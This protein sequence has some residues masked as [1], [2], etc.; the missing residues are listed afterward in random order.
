LAILDDKTLGFLDYR[1]NTESKTDFKESGY[2][3]DYRGTHTIEVKAMLVCHK[4]VPIA[5]REQLLANIDQLKEKVPA[6]NGQGFLQNYYNTKKIRQQPLI[7]WL[8]CLG[9]YFL[10]VILHLW[11]Y[12]TMRS[13]YH[14]KMIFSQ[15]N[16]QV[17]SRLPRNYNF[18]DEKE[19]YYREPNIYDAQVPIINKIADG[20]KNGL[21]LRNTINEYYLN[22][23]LINRHYDFLMKHNDT[24]IKK[25]RQV[26]GL[27]LNYVLV[28]TDNPAKEPLFTKNLLRDYLTYTYITP[29]DYDWLIKIWEK[30]AF[31]QINNQ[32]IDQLIEQGGL[33]EALDSLRIVLENLQ[34]EENHEKLNPYKSEVSAQLGRLASAKNDLAQGRCTQEQFNVDRNNIRT[35]I[36]SLAKKMIDAHILPQVKRKR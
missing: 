5:A 28:R 31:Y 35:A 6:L 29:L 11:A 24:I 2:H 27:R 32:Y 20:L 17:I 26:L 36:Q 3:H 10:L 14:Q 13:S 7:Q 8:S 33:E 1:Y 25:L 21:M 30:T 23:Y 19:K 18:K 16:E 9:A 34:N 15:I 4:N 12:R 22:K